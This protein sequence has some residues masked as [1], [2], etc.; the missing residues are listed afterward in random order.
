VQIPDS[1]FVGEEKSWANSVQ[2]MIG[3]TVTAAARLHPYSGVFP[4][5]PSVGALWIKLLFDNRDDGR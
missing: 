2:D 3:G 1:I 4:S 5:I